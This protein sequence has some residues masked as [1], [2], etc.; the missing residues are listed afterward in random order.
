M[1]CLHCRSEIGR[2]LGEC[3]VCGRAACSGCSGR[4]FS[5]KKKKMVAVHNEC[6]EDFLVWDGRAPAEETPEAAEAADGK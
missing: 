4:Q 5:T 1:S 6:R 2:A 3:V